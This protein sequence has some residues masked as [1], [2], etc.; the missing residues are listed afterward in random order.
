MPIQ[1]RIAAISAEQAAVDAQIATLEVK[2]VEQNAKLT[3]LEEVYALNSG[4]P[5]FRRLV[6]PR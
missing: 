3:D 1:D 6:H 2:M 5:T 4:A